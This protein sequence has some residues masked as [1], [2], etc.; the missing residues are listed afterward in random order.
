MGTTFTTAERLLSAFQDY[1]RM[2]QNWPPKQERAGRPSA[3]RFGTCGAQI[4]NIAGFMKPKQAGNLMHLKIIAHYYTLGI[5]TVQASNVSPLLFAA[6]AG[7]LRALVEP[8]AP[9]GSPIL[10]VAGS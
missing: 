1:F 4:A 10:P 3:S 9:V 5:R 7:C 2:N 6:T 8:G